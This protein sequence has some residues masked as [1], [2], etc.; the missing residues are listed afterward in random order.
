MVGQMDLF[1]PYSVILVRLGTNVY[2]GFTIK[3]ILSYVFLFRNIPLSTKSVRVMEDEINKG[4][5]CS[6]K[7]FDS[8]IWV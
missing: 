7:Q 3:Y 6:L 1:I 5:L 2:G 4:A 8:G